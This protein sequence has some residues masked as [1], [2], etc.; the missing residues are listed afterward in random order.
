MP[1]TALVSHCSDPAFATPARA[2]ATHAATI[3]NRLATFVLNV[4]S[5]RGAILFTD[6][7]LGQAFF[8]IY[9]A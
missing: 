7:M 3:L 9:V 8:V 5:R 6:L 4:A 2:V 1:V